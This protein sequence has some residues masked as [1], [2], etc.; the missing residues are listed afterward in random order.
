MVRIASTF[1]QETNTVPINVYSNLAS[2]LGLLVVLA[3]PSLAQGNLD[4]TLG[5]TNVE[6][7][8]LGGSFDVYAALVGYSSDPGNSVVLN[9]YNVAQIAGPDTSL[10]GGALSEDPTGYYTN[11]DGQSIL[12]GDSLGPGLLDSYTLAAGATPGVYTLDVSIDGTTPGGS[13]FTQPNEGLIT[14]TID[15]FVAPEGVS[16]V[17][18]CGVFAASALMLGRR[19]MRARSYTPVRRTVAL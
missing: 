19:K 15:E 11:Y 18:L 17:S 8:T 16:P 13:V 1:D 14:L 4:L 5:T 9:G 6:L 2:S 10:L 12:S 3:T 7:T